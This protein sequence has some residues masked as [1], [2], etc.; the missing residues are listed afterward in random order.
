MK[1]DHMETVNSIVGSTFLPKFF[2][3]RQ[4][5]SRPTLDPDQLPKVLLEDL[6]RINAREKIRPGMSIAITAGSRQIA[7]SATILRCLIE[8]VRQSGGIP[9]IVPAMGSHGGATAAGQKA[10]LETLGI[11]EMSVGCPI[12]SSMETVFV[13]QN[14]E[15]VDVY[16][17]RLAFEA[18]GIIVFN[19]IK[20][21]SGF[22]GRHESGLFKMM[23]IGLGK[24]YGAEKLHS[25]GI[26]HLARNIYLFG[27]TILE[28]S[29]IIFGVG[30]LENAYDETAEIHALLPESFAEMEPV[31][32]NKAFTYLPRILVGSCD[33]LIVS[34]LGKNYSGGGMD[35]NVTGRFCTSLF[36]GGIETQRIGVLD[37]SEETHGNAN[38][39]GLADVISK[40]AFDKIDAATTYP[41]ALTTTA[42]V[43]VRIPM[44]MMNDRLTMQAC[45]KGCY[46]IDRER[47][48][49]VYI[50]NTMDLEHIW[51]SEA[52]WQEIADI[53]GLAIDSELMEIPFDESG[54]ILE[55]QMFC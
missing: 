11:T 52:Y 50:R 35:P 41:N 13:G 37:L 31:Y 9:F 53:D 15:G 27:K 14:D 38:G 12:R 21:H 16:M 17:D 39:I 32:L 5:F 24:Q 29:K 54:N 7:N 34:K 33:A 30:V 47:P 49:V 10:M 40:R 2:R 26:A 28:N 4:S 3:A 42:Y 44:V 48:R 18:D 1:F 19:R 25:A 20:P 45:V 23:A 51:L 8:F 46:E 22:R 6:H 43:N 55:E 36:K